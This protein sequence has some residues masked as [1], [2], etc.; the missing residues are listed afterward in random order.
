LRR[1][2][3]VP[4]T[5]VTP[6]LNEA[7]RIREAVAALAWADE[8]IVIDG[9]STDRTPELAAEA[10]ATVL[11]VSVPTI[12][13]QRN[14][15]IAAAR[16]HWVLALDSDERV[17]DALRHELKSVLAAPVHEAYRIS[18][19]NA[20]LGRELH[21]G[22]WGR[23]SHVRL[24]KRERRFV[25]KRVH[26]ELESVADVGVL[27]SP[28]LH[29][30]YRDLTHHLEKIVRYARWGA[31]D[32]YERGR[33]ANVFDI[34]VVPAWRFFREYVMYSGW[35][36]GTRGLLTA[37]LD[38]YAGLLKYAYLYARQW[39]TANAPDQVPHPKDTVAPQSSEV[40]K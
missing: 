2:P 33:R 37:A 1:S 17:T 9:G 16:N 12:A 5:V 10:G 18:F 31:D 28:I 25:E 8:V 32:L 27:R 22:S 26:E 34:S 4:I 15:G 40:V 11:R 19:R 6:T 24:F 7:D 13:A 20:Y 35:L 23:D 3:E 21:H 39:R 14:A 29:T 36:D 38:A 30:T